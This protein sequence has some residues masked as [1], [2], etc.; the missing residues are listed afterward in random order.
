M[1]EFEYDNITGFPRTLYCTT[2][3]FC[4]KKWLS[5]LMLY[6]NHKFLCGNRNRS[7]FNL[8]LLKFVYV[9]AIAFKMFPENIY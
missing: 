7:E 6:E 9:Y 4:K 8:I 3:H 1:N 5:L 2:K